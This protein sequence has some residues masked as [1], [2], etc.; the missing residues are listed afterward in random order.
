MTQR[1]NFTSSDL[2]LKGLCAWSPKLMITLKILLTIPLNE[3]NTKTEDL[4]Y[5]GIQYHC[6]KSHA[7]FRNKIALTTNSFRH[8]CKYLENTE[9]SN[10]NS[11]QH[12]KEIYII[13]KARNYIEDIDEVRRK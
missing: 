13:D 4:I 8:N 7:E 5:S 12:M 6:E 2:K 10:T 11:S 1:N 9:Y 3:P